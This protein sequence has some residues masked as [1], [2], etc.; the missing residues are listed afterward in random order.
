M[1][2]RLSC[3]AS[4]A[5]PPPARLGAVLS[6]MIFPNRGTGRAAPTSVLFSG[7]APR[8][9]YFRTKGCTVCDL[10][11]M[12]VAQAC[13]RAGVTLTIVDRWPKEGRPT[14]DTP[15]LDEVGNVV[16]ADGS[17]GDA[18]GVAIYPT[19]ALIDRHEKLV[20][21][22]VGVRG[23]DDAFDSLLLKRFER[24]TSAG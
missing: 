17:V 12:R 24:L 22:G 10:I 3:D 19:F 5:G 2:I 20:W 14:E 18:F 16:D 8:L 6:N 15:Y 1:R 21:R 23:A 11:D 4:E 7:P 9:V 13:N